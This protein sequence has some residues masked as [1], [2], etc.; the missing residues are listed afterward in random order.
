[1]K[2]ID[3]RAQDSWI[4]LPDGR[5]LAARVWLPEES[6]LPA[7]A[8]LEYLPY[9]LR[10]GTAERDS[11]NYPVFAAAGY[12][13]V[14]VD[15]AGNG[16]SDGYMP[17]EYIED[18]LACGEKVIAWIAE[19]PW[20]NGSVGMIGI[21]WG[22]FNGLQIAMRRPPALKAI[23]T[24]CSTDNR[25]A[26]DIH[27]FGGC[28][29]G[30]NFM[31]G[32][33][34]TGYSCRP[35]DPQIRDDWREVWLDR[36]QRLPF[37]AANWLRHQRRDAHW[38]HGS[39]CEDW[40][41]IECPVL[42]VGGWAD[43]YSDTPAI[44]AARLQA[45][46]KAWVGPWEHRYPNLAK[47][48]PRGDFHAEVIRWFGKWLKDESNGAEQLPAYRVYVQQHDA[49]S[50]K[51][52]ARAGRWV[53]ARLPHDVQLE[54]YLARG[55]LTDARA[56]AETVTV[57]SEQ[58]V[59]E[60]AGNFC[61]GMRVD[62]E[63]A[64]D[65]R[66]DDEK[67]MCFDGDTLAEPVEILGAPQIEIEFSVDRPRA[68]LVFRLCDVAPD[69]VSDRVSFMAYNLT[70][71]AGHEQPADLIPGRRYR[72]RIVLRH[73]AHRFNTGHRIRL[74]V[75]TAYWPTVWPS[76]SRVKVNLHLE[77]CKL[78]LPLLKTEAEF[79]PPVVPAS[80]QSSFKQ[81]RAP[82]CTTETTTLDN[83]VRCMTLTD[84]MGETRNPHNGLESG[85][86]VC[87]RYFIHPNDPLQ[88]RAEVEWIHTHRR[89]DWQCAV[90][91]EG[92]MTADAYAFHLHRKISARH[93]DEVV[94][95]K[96]W[97]ETIPRDGC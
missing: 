12:A 95:E 33:Q 5:R 42:T 54:L 92:V 44:L 36:M 83:G 52:K 23:V 18:E 34:M 32:A 29:V 60:A 2:S 64:G 70:H 88:A 80:A 24:V 96:T 28:V 69:G 27:Y 14:R 48:G 16:D 86:S 87:H 79:E 53:E 71:H 74:A 9:R 15:M 59:G 10:D 66:H 78:G 11:G 31:W 65:Q 89:G 91:S 20:C 17:D 62:D 40:N 81:L 30:D 43:L 13:G 84:D 50:P 97:D 51:L 72:M 75:S 77:S 85:S 68:Q 46:T 58:D 76:P 21:S 82:S 63:L 55:T 39:V 67:S 57:D 22:G 47:V 35:P 1:M 61:A 4:E 6:A 73:C 56:G 94:L 8:I 38:K 7:P 3:Q 37:F 41:A 25:Y 26:G 19:Q 93:N 49:P 90:K 45:P